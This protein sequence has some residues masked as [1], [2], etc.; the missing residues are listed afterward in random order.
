MRVLHCAVWLAAFSISL[1][2]GGEPLDIDRSLLDAIKEVES[3]GNCCE[4][5]DHN[6][7]NK[8]YGAYQ[9]RA[10][11]YEDALQFNPD[12]GGSFKNVWG[13]GSDQYAEMV[14]RSYMGRYATRERLGR[15]PT[16][17]DIARIH[18]GGPNGYMKASTGPYWELVQKE[19]NRMNRQK[20]N[21]VNCA[22]TCNQNECCESTGCTCLDSSLMV[23]LCDSLSGTSSLA[24]FPGHE[25]S[26]SQDLIM[27]HNWQLILVTIIFLLV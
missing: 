13:K 6:L 3:E 5:G 7:T 21:V 4:I 16:Y 2:A 11:Y 10:P 15:D 23:V 9:I 27:N 25:A 22:L 1:C 19:L 26:T 14:V 8:A 20:R 18:N 24:S 12:L 17:E